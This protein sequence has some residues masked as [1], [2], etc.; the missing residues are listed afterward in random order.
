MDEN[1]II[2]NSSG[3]NKCRLEWRNEMMKQAF[4]PIRQNF[5]DDF[6]DDIA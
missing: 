1:G 4:E 6:V 3:G 2:L 5:G